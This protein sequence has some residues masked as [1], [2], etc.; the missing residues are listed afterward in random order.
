MRRWMIVFASLIVAACGFHLRGDYS[1]PFDT[2]YISLP[3]TNELRSVIKRNIE[4]S[5]QTKIVTDVKEAQA[6]LVVMQDNQQ[7]NILSLNSA[8]RVREYQLIRTFVFRVHDQKNQ[9]FVA[10]STIRLTREITF[11]DSAVLAKEAEESL[12]RRDMQ[13]DLVQQL[14]RR[15]AAAKLKS[16]EN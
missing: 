15:L 9:E 8:G 13:N 7:K 6:I 12:L 3:E 5:S 4:A 2:L 11:S 10:P 16:S 14:M 1:L